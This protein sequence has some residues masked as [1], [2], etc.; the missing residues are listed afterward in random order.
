MPETN[1]FVS[2]LRGIISLAAV[3]GLM[4]GMRH[5][6]LKGRQAPLH[7]GQEPLLKVRERVGLGQKSQAVLIQVGQQNFLVVTTEQGVTLKEL[8]E[9][10]Q[11]PE[12]EEMP[13]PQFASSLLEAMNLWRRG[14]SK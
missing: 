2:L 8:A 10:P 11:A 13:Q 7:T 3:F 6:L 1:Y 12:S 14:G 4:L 5:W 9:L